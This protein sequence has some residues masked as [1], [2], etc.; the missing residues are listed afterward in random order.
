[1][2][3]IE[4][5]KV[6]VQL[7]HNFILPSFC[8]GVLHMLF[9]N[10]NAA[11]PPNGNVHKFQY[12]VTPFVRLK[13]ARANLAVYPWAQGPPV[14]FGLGVIGVVLDD[15]RNLDMDVFRHLDNV[16]LSVSYY[17]VSINS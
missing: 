13:L 6:R 2:K 14:Q 15:P 1:M 3:R 5:A 12:V 17:L 11:A 4:A 9:A 8:D 10:L 7:F 16:R